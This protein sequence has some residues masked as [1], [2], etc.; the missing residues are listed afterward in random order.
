MESRHE[1]RHSSGW[2]KHKVRQ[3]R[4]LLFIGSGPKGV[5]ILLGKSKSWSS[6]YGNTG[7]VNRS[8]THSTEAAIL[9]KT[10]AGNKETHSNS[11]K[12]KEMWSSPSV[13][14]SQ[15]RGMKGVE[16]K[17]CWSQKP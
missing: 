13:S 17:E 8:K 2:W 16:T 10:S 15:I 11:D 6:Q 4:T 5:P 3:K 1:S 7:N 9:K 14:G 12:E